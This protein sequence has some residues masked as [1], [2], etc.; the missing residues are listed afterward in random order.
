[1]DLRQK[2]NARIQSFNVKVT[3]QEKSRKAEVASSTANRERLEGMFRTALYAMFEAFEHA[4]VFEHAETITHLRDDLVNPAISYMVNFLASSCCRTCYKGRKLDAAWRRSR[5][6]TVLPIIAKISPDAYRQAEEHQA[7]I[8]LEKTAIED[9]FTLPDIFRLGFTEE[10]VMI[11]KA[12]CR[13]E[14]DDFNKELTTFVRINTPIRMSR[15]WD[16]QKDT[17]PLVTSRLNHAALQ[18]IR[19]LQRQ[20]LLPIAQ[21]LLHR[22]RER[23]ENLIARFGNRRN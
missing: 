11:F 8:L 18:Q 5:F 13:S 17:P 2:G 3:R 21:A 15:R 1:M 16:N 9:G 12:L 19:Q 10:D 22:C 6:N 7:M 20:N 14:R 4:F 23:H